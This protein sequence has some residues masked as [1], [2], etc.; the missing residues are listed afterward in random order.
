MNKMGVFI[1]SAI[2]AMFVALAT[3]SFQ[4]IKAAIVNPVKSLRSE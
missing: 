4:V 2:L 3:V 1:L